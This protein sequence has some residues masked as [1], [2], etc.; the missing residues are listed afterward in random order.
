MI[1]FNNANIRKAG[2]S[3]VITIPKRYISDNILK[4]G[5]KYQVLLKEVQK[6]EQKEEEQGKKC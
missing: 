2:N 1:A 4:I 3:Y 6:D 5:Q